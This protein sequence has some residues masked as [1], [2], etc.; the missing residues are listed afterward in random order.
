MFI[1]AH[2]DDEALLTA[3]TMARAAAEGHRV[4][5]VMATDGAAGLTSA[6]FASDL[7]ARR[8]RELEVAA[9]VLDV[10]RL[11]WLGHRD[12]GI[13]G[14]VEGGFASLDAGSVAADI[15]ERLAGERCDVV[16]GYDPAGGYGHPDHRQV[17]RVAR[18]VSRLLSPIPA[19][20]EVTL[21]REPIVRVAQWA[22]RLHLTPRGFDPHEFDAAWTPRRGIT[23]RVDVRAHLG[24][25]RAALLAHASQTAADGGRWRTLRALTLLPRF[26]QV[27]ILGTEYYVAAGESDAT[28]VFW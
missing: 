5:L 28:G 2:P 3:G 8:R 18:L 6:A 10:H 27:R 13:L 26:V 4:I 7:G 17:H 15:V 25:K 16:V 21:P 9:H 20:F 22:S 19:L 11:E 23:H 14:D 1:H 12:S 24:A